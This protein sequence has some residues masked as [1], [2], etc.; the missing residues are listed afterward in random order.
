MIKSIYKVSLWMTMLWPL[1]ASA[2]TSYTEDFNA[3]ATGWN[4]GSFTLTPEYGAVKIVGRK[5]A[6]W[7]A[8]SK[9]FGPINI[10]TSPYVNIKIRSKKDLN[11]SLGLGSGALSEGKVIYP[12]KPINADTRVGFPNFEVVRSE[13]FQEYSFNFSNKVGGAVDFTKITWINIIINP[14]A[15]F[16]NTTPGEEFYIDD[17]EIG[18]AAK[19]TPTISNVLTQ[20][21]VVQQTG[22]VGKLVNLRNIT[23]GADVNSAV[24]VTASSSNTTLIS[25]ANVVV[26]YTSPAREGTL[27]IKPTDNVIGES[28]ITVKVSAPNAGADKS[29]TFKVVVKPNSPPV[30]D[31]IVGMPLVKGVTTKIPL[32]NVHDGDADA[33]QVVTI[34]T[35]SSAA[36][37]IPNPTV[38]FDQATGTGYLS[39]NPSASAANGSSSTISVVLTD[40]GGTIQG[41]VNTKT[42]TFEATVFA[43]VNKP[44]FFDA[45]ENQTVQNTSGIHTVTFSGVTNGESGGNNI[46]FSAVSSNQSVINNITFS[47]IVNGKSVMSYSTVGEGTANITV[48][49]TDAQG[50]ANNNGN[51]NYVR[52][53][54]INSIPPSNNS[55]IE[56]FDG[57]TVPLG[58]NGPPEHILSMDNG[59]LKVKAKFPAQTYPGTIIDLPTLAGRTIDISKNPFL[60]I[61]LKSSNANKNG[62]KVGDPQEHKTHIEVS[63]WDQDNDGAYGNATVNFQYDEDG[64]WHEFLLDYRGK[65][66]KNEK[67]QIDST[68]IKQVLITFDTRWW[69]PVE[70]E[71]W[72]DMIQM[73]EGLSVE[74]VGAVKGPEISSQT[75]FKGDVA[76]P[77]VLTGI[78]DGLGGDKVSF[79]ITNN[80]P[81]LVSNIA[82][83]NVVGGTAT[84][85]YTLNTPNVKLDSAK[86]RVISFNPEQSGFKRDTVDFYVFAV[87]T[88]GTAPSIVTVNRN[89]KFQ[90]VEGMGMALPGGPIDMTV[91]ASTDMN[92]TVFRVFGNF[93]RIEE[94][95][96]NGDPTVL[97]LEKFNF[98]MKSMSQIRTLHEAT[99]AKFFYTILTA[100]FWLKHN[101]A[102]HAFL[103]TEGYAFNN[104]YKADL[105]NEYAEFCVAI[106]R[107]F[108]AYAGVDLYGLSLQNEPEVQVP[109]ESTLV[110]PEEYVEMIKAVGRRFKAEGITTT[111]MM[112]EDVTGNAS[113]YLNQMKA[114]EKDAEARTYVGM[115]AIHIYDH[116]GINP[117]SGGAEIWAP[118]VAATKAAVPSGKLWMTETS[119]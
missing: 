86:I 25:N 14:L 112:P 13:D 98:D 47:P 23:D 53:F 100:P 4:G 12:D 28:I 39:I 95:N 22:S 83:S 97:A 110:T 46:S 62:V 32:T 75:I 96:D 18:T 8:F 106:V 117:G 108:K 17:I 102:K 88:I 76:K 20:G 6:Q 26:N 3:G 16:D 65:F 21:F 11:L 85:T 84:L 105:Y 103:G 31:A 63:L 109:Y 45:L 81:A 29:M 67:G 113:W 56:N 66:L 90:T 58:I 27:T 82:I 10:T 9:T 72:V 1:C 50:N 15:P 2:Q 33:L 74:S 73:G 89:E 78:N 49:L 101:K 93:D 87:D 59:A 94:T 71:Y 79:V 77:V 92:F 116:R 30:M 61:R 114:L 37:I 115:G 111:I 52:T 41:G 19:L 42:Y 55:F 35:S 57:T 48:T 34:T 70:G 104:R 54:A 80:K 43:Q 118:F 40:N 99:N 44:P 38:T 7:D 51:L 36:A 69:V 64:Q 91:N 68:K 119:G 60:K 5:T 24:T 107:G